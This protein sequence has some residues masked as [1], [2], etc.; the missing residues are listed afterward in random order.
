VGRDVDRIEI[1]HQVRDDSPT[2]PA[3]ELGK[4]EHRRI[5]AL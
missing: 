4:D 2:G 1:E 5:R 3:D